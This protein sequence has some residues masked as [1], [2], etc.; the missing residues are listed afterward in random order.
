ML[1]FLSFSLFSL[2][3]FSQTTPLTVNYKFANIEE[4]Y[5]HDSK[6]VVLIDGDV[7]G[8]SGVAPE[9]KGGTFT[10]QVP[11]GMHTLR[12]VNLALYEGVWEEHTIENNYSIDCF[13]ETDHFFKKPE[14]L[15]LLFD[16]DSE[17]SVSWKKPV[18]VK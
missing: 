12:V 2:A 10:V 8:E 16:V 7:V 5:D 17:T 4:G 18:K 13:Y 15:Y 14:K 11:T 3:L 6:T 9:S 1:V